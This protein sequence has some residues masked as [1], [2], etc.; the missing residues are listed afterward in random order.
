MKTYN[1]ILSIIFFLIFISAGFFIRSHINN[2]ILPA[3][4]TQ[5]L[6]TLQQEISLIYSKYENGKYKDSKQSSIYIL[7]T[8]EDRINEKTADELNLII[9]K[10]SF[11][12]LKKKKRQNKYR[13]S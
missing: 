13:K 6:A 7:E 1:K 8:Y 5:I 4:E 2:T 11:K 3:K 12:I 9:A 10:A